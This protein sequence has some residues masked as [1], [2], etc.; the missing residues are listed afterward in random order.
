MSTVHFVGTGAGVPFVYY[1][2]K[3]IQKEGINM[4]CQ[5]SMAHIRWDL[6]C[7]KTLL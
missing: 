1:V 5:E 6:S 7:Q 3:A 4:P 2:G